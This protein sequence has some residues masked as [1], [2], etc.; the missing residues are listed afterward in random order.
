MSSPQK[1]QVGFL[2]TIIII[3]G[4]FATTLG[5]VSVMAGDPTQDLMRASM[6][7]DLQ[8]VERLLQHEGVDINARFRDGFTALMMASLTNRPAI[9]KLLLRKG[10]DVN[11]RTSHGA[12]ALML[13]SGKG[14][15]EIVRLLLESGAELNAKET[16]GWTAL[17]HATQNGHESTR[18]LLLKHG[19]KE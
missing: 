5:T 12:T 7:G 8:K 19:A 14:S 11:A 6:A 16:S 13:A 1:C 18:A 9:V 3:T 10:A 4:I 2:R 15:I 17:T